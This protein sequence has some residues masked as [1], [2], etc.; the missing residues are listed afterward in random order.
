MMIEPRERGV[1]NPFAL[2]QHLETQVDVLKA[3]RQVQ[4]IES[5]NRL[6]I[7]PACQQARAC[8]R[9]AVSNNMREVKII[10]FVRKTSKRMPGYLIQSSDNARMLNRVIRK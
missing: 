1:H 8:D 5:P 10:R 2:H 3:G 7:A 4:F 6:E 9:A